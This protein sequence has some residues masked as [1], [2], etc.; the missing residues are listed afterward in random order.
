MFLLAAVKGYAQIDTE[1]W[2]AFPA[3]VYS[4]THA[5]DQLS[6]Y[7][8]TLDQAA[9]VTIS[10][11]RNPEFTPITRSLAANSQD[12][13]NL[14]SWKNRGLILAD[15]GETVEASKHPFGVLIESTADITVCYAN[16][17]GNAETYSLKGRN[18]LGTEFLVPMQYDFINPA[19]YGSGHPR[20]SIEMVATQDS[21][22]VTLFPLVE[23][24]PAAVEG[25]I[26][27]T[28][29]RG[30]TFAV[31]AKGI[32]GGDHLHNTRI[33]A[34]APIAVSFSDDAVY[35]TG[36]QATDL[37]GDQ[38]VPIR[39]AGNKYLVVKNNDLGT[40][41]IERAYIF[42]TEDT[43]TVTIANETFPVMNRGDKMMYDLVAEGK[44]AVMID[45]DKPVIVLQITSNGDEMGG[46]VLP[47][48]G[49]TGSREVICAPL[50]TS[51]TFALICRIE[52][53][54]N[55]TGNA[56]IFPEDAIYI[57]DTWAYI[58]TS[59][60]RLDTAEPLWFKNSSGIFHVALFDKPSN[61][62]SLGYYSNYN[63]VELN[64][65]TGSQ[66]T[67]EEENIE[68]S[69]QDG[70]NYIEVEWTAPDG[71]TYVDMDP[72]TP[73]I[74]EQAVP[75]DGGLYIGRGQHADQCIV[76]PDSIWVT[77]FAK[78][79]TSPDTV[80]S[81][82]G[83]EHILEAPGLSPYAWS[84]GETQNSI[85]IRPTEPVSYSVQSFLPGQNMVKAMTGSLCTDEMSTEIW[86]Y[87]IPG[88]IPQG[89][90]HLFTVVVNT[91]D[92]QVLSALRFEINGNRYVPDQNTSDDG[93]TTLTY[94]WE[95]NA[96]KAEL[97]IVTEEP[98]A[99]ICFSDFS[100]APL[101]QVEKTFRIEIVE[102]L[103]PTI[104]AGNGYLC[105]GSIALEVLETYSSY[106]WNTGDTTSTLVVT[107]PGEYSV[108]VGTDDCSGSATVKVLPT[109]QVSA[110]LMG[111][112]AVCAG[113]TSFDIDCSVLSGE[114]ERYELQF[115]EL[116]IIQ[117]FSNQ[118]GAFDG[119]LLT[120]EVP[121]DAVPDVYKATLTI[122][123]SIC[124]ESVALPLDIMVKY[125]AKQ[126]IAQRWNEV[127]G[128]KNAEHNGGITF[129]AFQWYKNG[130]PMEGETGA[131]LYVLDRFNGTDC[132][133]VMLTRE[134]GVQILSCDTCPQLQ[135]EPEFPV[136]PTY[137]ERGKTVR[138]QME[139]NGT[140]ILCQLTGRVEAV[141]PFATGSFSFIAPAMPGVYVLQIIGDRLPGTYKIIVK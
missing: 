96:D 53:L 26:E 5:D 105:G 132:Y 69:V 6:L 141:L 47:S 1:F 23:T 36:T 15:A 12:K 51:P 75:E 118:A 43:T 112:A 135:V 40:H 122:Y 35:P 128:V 115:D 116:A 127:L 140:A 88:R 10:Q 90:R 55:F 93:T 16:E 70:D 124:D 73:F 62:C 3:V 117:G 108:T 52:D 94:I 130:Q 111:V 138:M 61:A 64:A 29:G 80:Y 86:H 2:F 24:T 68:L 66:Y 25:K 78:E 125:A 49:C 74:I 120:V 134:D 32:N 103:Q 45:S 99:D 18:A 98:V 44:E 97:A 89:V 59:S 34:D 22:H 14:T 13:I 137:V 104:D 91:T 76:E 79:D 100:F 65:S 139:G 110:S 107:Q 126:V 136:I 81:C 109:P 84:T 133:A 63:T 95:M 71:S 58:I 20:A 114:V 37:V 19:T 77:V 82:T 17:G 56:W 28:L 60:R 31:K 27:V 46:T 39:L 131:N 72:A 48:L 119:G 101:F 7:I 113:E 85:S 121:A 83:I 42:P 123:E 87:T 30:E 54:E 41:N 8:A 50:S 4:G 33:E 67:L 129:S 106:L 11:P 38:L 57:D 102:S 92:T 21:T 9:E